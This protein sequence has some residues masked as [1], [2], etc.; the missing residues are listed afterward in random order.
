MSKLN[1]KEII[2]LL[3]ILIGGTEPIGET[4]YDDKVLHNLETLIDVTNWCLDGVMQAAEFIHRP[5]YS[6]NKVGFQAQC[7][8]QEWIDWMC[9]RMEEA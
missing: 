2:K 3:D 4:N 7:A 8:M 1:S 9:E 6:M 5:E